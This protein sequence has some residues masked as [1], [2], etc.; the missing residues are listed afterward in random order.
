MS[1]SCDL[2]VCSQ[3]DSSVHRVLQARIL[4]WVALFCF[5]DLPDPEI[6]PTSLKSPELAGGF[7]FVFFFTI[8]ATWE[9]LKSPSVLPDSLRPH[10]L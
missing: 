6:E 7:F 9:A 5:R 10:G 3:S 1:D 2:M 8:R 4:E